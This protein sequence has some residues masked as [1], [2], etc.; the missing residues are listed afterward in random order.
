MIKLILEDALNNLRIP[1]MWST[2]VDMNIKDAIQAIEYERDPTSSG[3]EE[4]EEHEKEK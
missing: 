3:E 4:G 1:I 2:F